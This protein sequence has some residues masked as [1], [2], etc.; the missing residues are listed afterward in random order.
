MITMD[1]KILFCGQGAG[2]IAVEC[3]TGVFKAFEE[4]GTIPGRALT[5]SGS[6]LFASLY[7][8]VKTTDWMY[9]LMSK[10]SVSDF[11]QLKPIQ[12]LRTVCSLNNYI[13]ENENVYKI[14]KENMTGE[15]S[16]RVTTSITRN[17]DFKS[18]LKRVTPAV[19]LAATSIPLIFK[20]VRI[21]L[22]YYSDGGLLN[23][24]PTPSFEE[25]KQWKHIFI[26]LAP[27]T[28]IVNKED[29]LLLT[30]LI[31]LLN[32]IMDRENVQFQ[33]D[34]QF[35]Q[36]QGQHGPPL[37]D[38][39][40]F[41]EVAAQHAFQPHHEPDR[42]R[43]VQVKFFPQGIIAGEGGLFGRQLTA[44][45]FADHRTPRRVARRQPHQRVTREQDH[46]QGHQPEQQ[47]FQQIPR[48]SRFHHA[49]ASV[50]PEPAGDR[51]GERDPVPAEQFERMGAQ[52]IH[53][54]GHHAQR[55]QEGDGRTDGERDP[56]LP[57]ER[58]VEFQQ[59][60]SR[61]ADHGRDRDQERE[62]RRQRTRRAKRQR[63]EDRGRRTRHPRY[64]RQTLGQTDQQS[65]AIRKLGNRLRR[66]FMSAPAF[67]PEQQD[68]AGQQR[69]DPDP[70]LFVQIIFPV[71]HGFA[72]FGCHIARALFFKSFGWIR[73]VSHFLRHTTKVFGHASHCGL[74]VGYHFKVL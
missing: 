26:F 3:L 58:T 64:D 38:R 62:F 31:N 39:R 52:I 13:F 5:S 49:P 32:A 37:V 25:A 18:I 69:A 48:E 4:F 60:V 40:R 50:E 35:F 34:R 24:I 68:A 6:T 29:D 73:H 41:A 16:K 17:R 43:T 42:H 65:R 55:D 30:T 11:I 27:P 28:K 14:L 20:P 67:D 10:T 7:Y 45:A 15:A 23:N 74:I 19:T 72:Y 54:P 71:L 44:R 59:T 2:F 8:S 66:F 51:N 56:F 61:G 36:D 53:Q 12:T 70:R 21:G 9:D 47:A 33:G 46:Q 57:G 22:D 63:R 1:D